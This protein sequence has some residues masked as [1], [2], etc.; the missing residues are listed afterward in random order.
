MATRAKETPGKPG[1]APRAGAG[2]PKDPT[3]IAIRRI[4]EER[5]E[6][7]RSAEHSKKHRAEEAA[8]IEASGMP[9]FDADFQRMIMA[10]R[11]AAE[12]PRPHAAP[13]GHDIC[14]V[15]RKR[16]INK[17]ETAARDWDAVTCI[18]PRVVVHAPKLKVDGITK[19]L[20]NL[21]F[22]FDHVSDAGCRDVGQQ[23][24]CR[25]VLRTHS[26]AL[27]VVLLL[28]CARHRS[29]VVRRIDICRR[30]PT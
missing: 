5:E 28:P 30:P 9:I 17:R 25:R 23:A 12:D 8:K 6:R 16:P 7:R 2:G 24:C 21:Q 14:V 18:N 15:V 11:A 13:G 27:G 1:G 22:A 19:Y 4:Q 26:M 3:Y 10:F 20:D 29:N